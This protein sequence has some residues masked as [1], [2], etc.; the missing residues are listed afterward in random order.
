MSYKPGDDFR[1]SIDGIV[2][3]IVIVQKDD[4]EINDAAL[5]LG[6][7]YASSIRPLPMGAPQSG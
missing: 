4:R 3:R 1:L 6:H 2:T 7:S 5:D